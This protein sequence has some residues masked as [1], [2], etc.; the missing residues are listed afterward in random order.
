MDSDPVNSAADDA[1]LPAGNIRLWVDAAQ[2]AQREPITT[3]VPCGDCNACCRASY[4]IHI[5]PQEARALARIPKALLFKA[6]GLPAG[7]VLM[8]YDSDGRCPMLVGASCSIYEDRPQTC[9]DYDCR[10]FAATGIAA[11]G[12]HKQDINRRV[13]RWRFDAPEEA[14]KQ[15][16]A[17]LQQAASFLQRHAGRFPAGFVPGHPTQLALLA[18]A[19]HALFT[20]VDGADALPGAADDAHID[21]LVAAI[22]TR[23]S[24]IEGAHAATAATSKSMPASSAKTA[25]RR[26]ATR[27]GASTQP[28]TRRR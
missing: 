17:A 25:S 10:L 18:L 26:P 12:Q 1:P 24:A 28:P 2:R 16:A 9:R 7:H 20:T 23:R 8:G 14:D 21:R 13:A 19:V 4:F 15:V 5:G 3:D 11:G 6:P 27:T 22:V